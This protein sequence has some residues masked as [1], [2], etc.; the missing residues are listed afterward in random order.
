[1]GNEAA[2]R[3][4]NSCRKCAAGRGH[5]EIQVEDRP[6]G[7]EPSGF[8]LDKTGLEP[9]GEDCLRDAMLCPKLEFRFI[10]L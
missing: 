9:I 4:S 1:M 10:Y 2:A 7:G 3:N 8:R 6:F 5:P